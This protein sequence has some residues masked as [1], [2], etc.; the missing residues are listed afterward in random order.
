MREALDI[1]NEDP[2][3][4]YIDHEYFYEKECKSNDIEVSDDKN[5]DKQI[6]PVM[7]YLYDCS[8]NPEDLDEE[9]DCLIDNYIIKGALHM[10]FAPPGSGKT[11]LAVGTSLK[12]L[13]DNK[14]DEVIYIDMDNS[15]PV[16][17]SRG[18]QQ[19]VKKYSNFILITRSKGDFKAKALLKK[20]SAACKENPKIYEGKFFVFDSIRD[21]LDGKDMNSDKDII[22]ILELLKDMRDM[23][24]ATI[25]FLHH[26]NRSNDGVS[27]KGSSSFMDSVDEGFSV[28]STR[29]T[30]GL[31]FKLKAQKKRL[32]ETD[33]AF[34][35]NTSG[36]EMEL[37]TQDFEKQ[38][39]KQV[40][41]D[42]VEKA[43]D[44]LEKNHQGLSQSA[45]LNAMGKKE[46][47]PTAIKYLKEHVN[48]RWTRKQIPKL[49]NKI[50][51]Y[52]INKGIETLEAS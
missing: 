6:L 36:E 50:M 1:Y 29:T 9:V 19:I 12:L 27:Y 37:I 10:A 40:E 42:V 26:T 52:P 45:L 28:A 41:V 7:Q 14:V 5:L 44:I 33:L 30:T 46:T 22:P 4:R 24:K 13:N 17:K 48:K 15:T 34:D 21:F 32:F 8:L 39:M 16:L 51:Y 20:L 18:L 47:D 49:N 43:E 23:G 2:N 35:L 25:L 31:S 11:F 3:I 38:N